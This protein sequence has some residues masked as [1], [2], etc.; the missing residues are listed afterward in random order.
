MRTVVA[1]AALVAV[2]LPHATSAP[3][4]TAP[5]P[6]VLDSRF[7]PYSSDL[8]HPWNRLHRA[9]FVRSA[10]DGH[11]HAHTTDPLLYRGGTF[12][13]EGE[14]HREALAELDRFLAAEGSEKVGVARRVFLQR[15]LWAAFDYAAWYPDDWVF[16]SKHEPAAIALRSKLAKAIGRLAASDRELAALP[17]NYAAAVKSKRFAVDHDPKHPER[18]F[19][20]PDLFDADGPWV[21]F[22]EDTGDPMTPQHFEGAGGRAA[23]LVYIRLPG[24]RAATDRYVTELRGGKL[25]PGQSRRPA[26]EQFPEGTM[27]AMV[28][29]ALAV[30]SGV[31]VRPTP[32]TE[33]VQIRVYRKIPGAAEDSSRTAHGDQDV[34]EFVLDRAALF[35]GG[36]GLRAVAPDE[37]AEPLF[38]RTFGDPVRLSPPTPDPE[39]RPMTQLRT[40]TGCHQSPGVH[41]VL[42]MDRGLRREYGRFRTYAFDVELSYSVKAKVKQFDWGLL[43]GKLEPR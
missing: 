5:A 22:H 17:D 18:P 29:R 16:K 27:V 32:L 13:I 14:S 26:V 1:L 42:S 11:R 28:R 38:G 24:G 25:A 12:L 15:D 8:N 23:H 6:R 3:P 2:V 43:Q 19:L 40:C 31:K 30:D 33:L 7:V 20:P 36:H 34:Y 35:A 10:S 9:L 37:P 39:A 4:A 21:R 41:S